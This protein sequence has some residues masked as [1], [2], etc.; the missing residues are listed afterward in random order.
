MQ[1]D[2]EYLKI[3]IVYLES[4]DIITNSGNDVTGDDIYDDFG[5]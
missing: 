2:Y 3:E 1:K 4:Q 5:E